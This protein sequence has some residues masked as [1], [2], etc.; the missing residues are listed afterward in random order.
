MTTHTSLK[1]SAS[2]CRSHWF[3]DPDKHDDRAIALALVAFALVDRPIEGRAGSV[4][5]TM[6]PMPRP[7]TAS[8]TGG[9][10]PWRMTLEE[11]LRRGLRR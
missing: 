2:R 3:H 8:F 7:P 1:P 11:S 9:A 4:F 10:A 5:S 6:A